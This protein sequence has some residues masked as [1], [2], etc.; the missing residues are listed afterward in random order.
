MNR[1]AFLVLMMIFLNTHIMVAQNKHI[2]FLKWS[3][4]QELPPLDGQSKALGLAGP[5]CGVHQD[6]LMVGGGAN[7]PNM[8]PWLGG[9]KKYYDDLYIYTR[10]HDTTSLF[11]LKITLPFPVAYAASCST[12]KG[13]VYVGGENEHGLCNKVFLLKW[14]SSTKMVKTINLPDFPIHVANASATVSGNML[15]VAGGENATE[16]T[17]DFYR[18]DLGE[19]GAVWVKLASIPKPVSHAVSVLQGN[20]HHPCIYVMGGR[21]KNTNGI[22]E[23]Y[24]SVYEY[25]LVTGRWLQKKSMPYPMCAGTGIAGEKQSV[26]MFGG[27]KGETFHQV[28][29]LLASILKETDAA[30]KQALIAQKNKI[31]SSHPGFSKEI[32]LY[33]AGKDIW[34]SA[35]NIHFEVPVTTFACWWGKNV[36]IPTGE[37][38][39]GL[40]TPYILSAEIKYKHK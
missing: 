19:T 10:H 15:F 34:T 36:I 33:D 32:L 1:F 9:K 37:V 28:E 39:A 21:K 26:L 23:F 29:I 14:D 18:L 5:V 25:D 22:S 30:K 35:G 4:T 20:G 12:P 16:T 2:E 13:I 6:V 8:M 7:F 17:D 40:R 11:P 3:I 27:D 31:Q 38:R 24:S